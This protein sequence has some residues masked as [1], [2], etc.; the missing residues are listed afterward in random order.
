[1]LD[2]KFQEQ[3][4]NVGKMA[5]N[6]IQNTQTSDGATRNLEE[7]WM[8]ISYRTT[9]KCLRSAVDI[10]ARCSQPTRCFLA[11]IIGKCEANISDF[12]RVQHM[13]RSI[14]NVRVHESTE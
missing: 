6:D 9:S 12:M 13:S 3:I 5:W 10:L 7:V 14:V 4:A 11:A 2:A 8:T 1:M